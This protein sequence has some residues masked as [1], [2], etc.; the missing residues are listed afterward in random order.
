MKSLPGAA[1]LPLFAPDLIGAS[2]IFQSFILPPLASPLVLILLSY[3][4]IRRPPG[5][6]KLARRTRSLRR[7]RSHRVPNKSLRFEDTIPAMLTAAAQFRPGLPLSPVDHCTS[8]LWVPC[9]WACSLQRLA[10]HMG[11]YNVLLKTDV[12]LS[13]LSN[14]QVKTAGMTFKSPLRVPFIYL[15]TCNSQYLPL[16]QH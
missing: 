6:S 10:H 2:I 7:E 15:C 9:L 1:P 13:K 3:P 8:P 16:Q 11:R 14:N 5:P 12:D 4:D